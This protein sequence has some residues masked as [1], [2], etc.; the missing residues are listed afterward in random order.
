M[1]MM[2]TMTMLL[3]PS[4]PPPRDVN[5]DQIYQAEEG[6]GCKCYSE[7]DSAEGGDDA[8]DA[9][10]VAVACWRKDDDAR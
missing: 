9:D 8:D 7:K 6:V 3:F 2:T 1:T 10:A 5:L 4:S